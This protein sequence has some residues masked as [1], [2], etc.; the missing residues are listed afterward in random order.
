MDRAPTHP[1]EMLK[2][3]FLEPLGLTQAG[4]AERIGVSFTR[5]NEVVN[6]RRGVTPNTALRLA[7]LLGTTPEFWLSGQ[8]AWDLYHAA[9]SPGV[10]V[11]LENIHS[12]DRNDP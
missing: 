2:K 9:R 6:G 3:E 8:L 5:V 4:L 10:V 12:I 11:A 1:G 7:K